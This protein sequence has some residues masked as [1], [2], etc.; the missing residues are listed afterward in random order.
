MLS[1]AGGP[2]RLLSQDMAG[3]TLRPQVPI[4]DH[5]LTRAEGLGFGLSGEGEKLAFVQTGGT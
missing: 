1:R 3:E 5:P 4:P 2:G